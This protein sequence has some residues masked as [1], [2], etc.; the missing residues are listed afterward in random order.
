MG[1]I[2]LELIKAGLALLVAGITLGLTWIVGAKIAAKW[3][4]WQKQREFQLQALN[5]FYGFYGEWMSV[6]R[7]W[8][9][10]HADRNEKHGLPASECKELEAAEISRWHLLKRL[11]NAEANL[12][13]V[14]LRLA[15]EVAMEREDIGRVGLFR[16]S[17]Q[18][19]RDAIRRDAPL[20]WHTYDPEFQKLR[21][22]AASVAYL[23]LPK[24]D[25][26]TREDAI[27]HMAAISAIL[28][29]EWHKELAKS[30]TQGSAS[31]QS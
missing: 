14:F 11:V 20:P 1:P 22:L 16:R 10:Y 4:L 3:S 12:E 24:E 28:S 30:T 21:E 19:L 13:S 27:A 26:K 17:T 6:F 8:F 25:S 9:L 29:G 7:L 23:I 18:A 2:R 5:Q 15:S 31:S